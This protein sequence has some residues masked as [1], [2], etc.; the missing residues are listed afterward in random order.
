MLPS[1]PNQHHFQR[2]PAQQRLSVVA[3]L[4]LACLLLPPTKGMAYDLKDN[5]I[6]H[7]RNGQLLMERQQYDE[8]IEEFKAA[9]RLNPYAS[10]AA[11]LYN[12]LGMAYRLTQNYPNAYASFQRAIRLQP[13]FALYYR[14]LID[15]YRRA[16]Q[17]PA[18]KSQLI[19]RTR[20][21]P[22]NAEAW[23]LL[24]LAYQQEG[25][26]EQAQPCFERF[27]KLQPE[28]ELARAAQAA[29]KAR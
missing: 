1:F 22:D 7:A 26:P 14:N 16:G 8:A 28:A 20:D 3:G 13:P 19:T 2:H 17:L 18:V 5:A 9:I 23:F 21:N 24:G 15:T 12:N 25:T 10:M 11:S 6:A 4:L 27:L 29:L